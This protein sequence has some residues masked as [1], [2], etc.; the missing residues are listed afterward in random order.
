MV[1]HNLD[2]F[3]TAFRPAEADSI[4]VVESNAVLSRSIPGELLKPV[5][6]QARDIFQSFGRVQA[7]Q[8]DSSLL[9][10][11]LRQQPPGRFRSQAAIDVFGRD[12]AEAD[13][14][15]TPI[16]PPSGL[17][18]MPVFTDAHGWEK[19]DSYPC[20]SGASVKPSLSGVLKG[21]HHGMIRLPCSR[22]GV[23]AGQPPPR[24]PGLA[25]T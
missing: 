9:M 13:D 25:K 21:V 14:C 19:S 8:L 23:S 6:R 17:K 2:R 20:A 3:G 7:C 18:E 12:I 4:L 10:Q 16:I 1:I 5:A 15:H 11:L 24:S 22:L